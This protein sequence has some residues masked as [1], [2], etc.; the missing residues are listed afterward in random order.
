MKFVLISK[1]ELK[2]EN[3]AIFKE[4]NTAKLVLLL[5]L[6][7]TFAVYYTNKASTIFLSKNGL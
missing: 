5:I 3:N 4:N 1:P 6:N 7:I 2:C